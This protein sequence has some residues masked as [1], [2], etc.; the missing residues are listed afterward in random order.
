MIVIGTDPIQDDWIIVES[1]DARKRAATAAEM[2]RHL[3]MLD[4]DDLDATLLPLVAAAATEVAS[5]TGIPWRHDSDDPPVALLRLIAK[6]AVQN[7]TAGGP[8]TAH[9]LDR[10]I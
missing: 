3:G 6:V 2:A 7:P 1:E 9:L 4:M 8:H 10:L 5:L